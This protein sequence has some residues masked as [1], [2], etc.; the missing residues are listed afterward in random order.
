MFVFSG[1]ITSHIWESKPSC[2]NCNRRDGLLG[3]LD[4]FTFTTQFRQMK[5]GPQM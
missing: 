2:L 3:D 1:H 5:L 4:V